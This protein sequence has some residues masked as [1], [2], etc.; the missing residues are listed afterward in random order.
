MTDLVYFVPLFPLLGF[1]TL[2]V[3]GRRLGEP[4]AGWLATAACGGSFLF[5]IL[6]FI[7]LLRLDGEERQVEKILFEW[8]PVGRLSV[9]AGF[10]VDP[11]SVAMIL[12]VT[13]LGMLIHLYSIGYMHGDP[14]Y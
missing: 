14:H 12:F 13:G 10:L 9:D 6:T 3:A 7:G 2:V 11:L 5:S 1:V 8:V 4:M